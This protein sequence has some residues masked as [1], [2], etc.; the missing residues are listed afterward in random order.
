MGLFSRLA[1]SLLLHL[2]RTCSTV[3]LST[4]MPTAPSLRLK[5]EAPAATDLPPGLSPQL[6]AL[7]DEWHGTLVAAQFA[8]ANR[9][10]ARVRVIAAA[11]RW[12]ALTDADYR[13]FMRWRTDFLKTHTAHTAN[14]HQV[15]LGRFLQYCADAGLVAENWLQG[16][17]LL[18]SA[19][20]EGSR[21]FTPDELVR[22][23]RTT[24][25]AEAK[26][27]CGRHYSLR[28]RIYRA[29][30]YSGL[31][32]RE[33]H[34]LTVRMVR[35]D[36]QPPVFVLDRIGKAKRRQRVEIP[37]H[38]ELVPM[39]AE[40]CRGKGPDAP[41]FRPF[42]GRL[43][44]DRD[45]KRAGIAKTNA[46]G[47]KISFHG[48]RHTLAQSGPEFG[49][50]QRSMQA[51]MRHTSPQMTAQ[52]Y[53]KDRY[54][55]LVREQKK[56]PT[57]AELE[58][59]IHNREENLTGTGDMGDSYGSTANAHTQSSQRESSGPGLAGGIGR[60]NPS[61]G[62]AGPGGSRV[63]SPVHVGSQ[64]R[65]GGSNP[66]LS[67]F[68]SPVPVTGTGE[69]VG[70]LIGLALRLLDM[71]RTRLESRPCLVQPPPPPHPKRPPSRR[72]T[73]VRPPS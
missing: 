62:E 22:L 23:I 45:L 42:V 39:L 71:A 25:E 7:I 56:I 1:R 12:P 68:Q 49:V 69:E 30:A 73:S 57:L 47:Q 24:E 3:A 59:L 41:V 48:F 17:A 8:D 2:D 34:L 67:A 20:G 21:P 50:D 18:P 4:A 46:Y 43:Q 53:Q 28:S 51:L 61:S 11:C 72:S 40:L 66:S 55:P 16:K 35:L 14:N 26:A 54:L 33:L 38:P 58:R 64:E 13:T 15:S 6:A 27:T 52:V 70:E 9:Y 19:K 44:L 29:A 36:A 5:R 60:G 31:R 63:S 32:W 65:V 37:V 10:A